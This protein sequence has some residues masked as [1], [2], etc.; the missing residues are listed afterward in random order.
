MITR[1]LQEHPC[2]RY[3]DIGAGAG[4]YGHM[5]RNLFSHAH[6]EAVEIEKDYV[7]R[8]QLKT[9]YQNVYQEDIVSF[10]QKYPDYETDIVIIG[11]C[12]EHLKKSDG[13]DVIHFFVYRCQYMIVVFPTAYVQYSS[14]GYSSE[15]HRSVWDEH[16]FVQFEHTYHREGFMN[17]VFVRGYRNNSQATTN[18]TQSL[19]DKVRQRMKKFVSL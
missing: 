7:D 3:L 4:K 10:I 2:K 6:I 8:F 14:D 11:D 18:L 12:I 13:I 1:F 9:L 19:S 16:D 15:A 5:I 17:A